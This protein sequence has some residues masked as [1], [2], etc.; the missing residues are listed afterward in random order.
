MNGIPLLGHDALDAVFAWHQEGPILV[1][2][3]LADV[4]ALQRHL[5]PGRFLLNVCQDRYH[6]VVG[7]AA[8]SL[9]NRVSLQ[10][11]S[12]SPETIRQIKAD[13]PDITCLRDGEFDCLD[14]PYIDFPA[15]TDAD[16]AAI[17]AI[18]TVPAE[19][20]AA[21]LFTSGSTGRPM[22]HAKHWGRLHRNGRAGAERL[23][24]L[25][26]R[27]HVVGTVPSQHSYG[28]ES[29]TLLGLQGH[30]PF[31][32]GNPFYPQDI[33]AA[34]EAVPEPRM[35]VTTPFHLSTLLAS[36]L[37]L[38]AVSQ[39]LSATAPLSAQL[40]EEA[41]RRFGAPLFEIYGSTESGQT[42]SRRTTAGPAWTLLDG[43]R[44]DQANDITTAFDGHVEGRVPL[45]DIIE[46]M[47]DRQFLLHGR[48]ADVVN[49]AG[50]RTSI[51]YLNHQIAAIPGVVDAA[52]FL[53]DD[54]APNGITRLCAFVVAPD[55][56]NRQILASL[57]PRIEPIFLPRPLIRVDALPRNST[58]KLSRDNLEKLYQENI[59]HARR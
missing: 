27:H 25:T 36:S 45:S 13:Y 26:R 2:D 5:P 57:R 20:I 19:H 7:L 16:P 56:D 22:P 4:H 51:A 23:G 46:L 24:L 14:L 8:G 42:A 21:I 35:L 9:S 17:V 6:F 30:A 3:M 11:S 18:P 39:V 53:P 15:L 49:I 29:T 52:F 28:F 10:P 44:F 59:G 40:A 37:E 32:S 1:R 12:Q 43:V 55:L 47:N 34:L 33:V 48:H 41:E 31:W 58:G 50:K 38:P 54:V